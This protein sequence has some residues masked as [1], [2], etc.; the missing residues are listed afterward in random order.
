MLYFFCLRSHFII[1]SSLILTGSWAWYLESEQS[2]Y[3]SHRQLGTIPGV[4]TVHSP[5][6]P[7]VGHD[8]WN[9]N[10]PQSCHTAWPAVRH[11]TWNLNSPQSCHTAW[12]PV[13]HD[14]RNL[15][16]P[17]SCHTAWPPVR[18]DTWNLNSPQSC[19]TG[20]WAWYLESEQSTVLSHRLL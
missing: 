3:R 19:H 15:N 17:Q 10:S 16:S 14:T 2:T 18:H 5:V 12:P 9:L 11:D 20:S 7:S 13:R 8:T 1:P 4:W 6:T